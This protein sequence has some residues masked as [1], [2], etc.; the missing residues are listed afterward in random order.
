[1][2]QQQQQQQLGRSVEDLQASCLGGLANIIIHC[3]N[4]NIDNNN[5]QLLINPFL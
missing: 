2:E 4:N 1:M 3:I 5:H